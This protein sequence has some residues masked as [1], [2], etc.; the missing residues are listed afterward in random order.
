MTGG[1][2]S[3]QRRR[4]SVRIQ[5]VGQS[6]RRRCVHDYALGV[7]RRPDPPLPARNGDRSTTRRP[8]QTRIGL[9]RE[10]IALRLNFAEPGGISGETTMHAFAR[11]IVAPAS[12][13]GI[14]LAGAASAFAQAPAPPRPRRRISARSKSRPPS[15]PTTST[16]SRA[17]GTIGVLT[18]PDGVFMVDSQFAPLTDKIVAAIKQISTADPVHGQH[19]RA[20]RSHRRQREPR[21][22]GRRDPLARSAARSGWPAARDPRRRRRC[23]C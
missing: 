13:V 6:L 23:R 14:L 9:I 7:G 10:I 19:A 1:T 11:R 18:G 8:R 15:S 20:R 22:D 5:E 3:F 12:F 21:Q 4:R 2:R 17:G 16:R